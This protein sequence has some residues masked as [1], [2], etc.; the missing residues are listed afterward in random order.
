MAKRRKIFGVEARAEV[1]KARVIL[2]EAHSSPPNVSGSCMY[3]NNRRKYSTYRPKARM[4]ALS[5][6]RLRVKSPCGLVMGWLWDEKG[7]ERRERRM[8]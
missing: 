8:K 4:C 3:A 2:G 5:N 7:S 1:G 6:V